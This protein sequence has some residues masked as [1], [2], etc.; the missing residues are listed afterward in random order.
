MAFGDACPAA[1]SLIA[2]VSENAGSSLLRF[3]TVKSNVADSP[4][5]MWFGNRTETPTRLRLSRDGAHETNIVAS[6][7]DSTR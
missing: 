3:V 4:A 2:T 7:A 5:K 6:S 1:P